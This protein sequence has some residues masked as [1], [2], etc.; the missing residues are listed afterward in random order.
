M[1]NRKIISVVL[2]DKLL[3]LKMYWVALFVAFD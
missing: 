3:E 2:I 1:T